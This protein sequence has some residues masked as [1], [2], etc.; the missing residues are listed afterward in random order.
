ML[1]LQLR[2][3]PGSFDDGEYIFRSEI[4]QNIDTHRFVCEHL[5]Y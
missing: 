5:L 3:V 2:P 1:F 4:F